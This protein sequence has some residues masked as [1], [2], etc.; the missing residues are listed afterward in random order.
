MADSAEICNEE[1]GEKKKL[2]WRLAIGYRRRKAY[3]RAAKYRRKQKRRKARR[4]GAP[5][6][7]WRGLS[8]AA[9]RSWR[10][11]SGRRAGENM[12]WRKLALAQ[13]SARYAARWLRWRRWRS[14]LGIGS[15]WLAQYQQ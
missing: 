11:V 7:R 5:G 15:S 3:R 8:K 9:A 6:W 4:S 1:N 2:G 13:R 14:A 10:I 12:Q